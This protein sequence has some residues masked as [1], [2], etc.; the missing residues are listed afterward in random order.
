VW[1]PEI[2]KDVQNIKSKYPG[3]RRIDLLTLAR[4]PN[5]TLSRQH[6]P[7]TS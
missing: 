6:Q 3:V 2:T 5:T 1:E 4:A 7:Q